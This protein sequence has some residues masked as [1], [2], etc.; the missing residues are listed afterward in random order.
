MIVKNFP[1]KKYGGKRKALQTAKAHRDRMLVSHRPLSRAEFA[2]VL[3]R[4]NKSGVPGVCLVRC[5]YYLVNGAERELLYW[6]AIWPSA[7]SGR[8]TKR[9]SVKTHG[10]QG[11]FELACRARR[12]GLRK[13]KGTFWASARGSV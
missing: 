12:T 8:F 3:R 11:A 4:N 9:F 2:N 5:K 6:E 10:M 1:D 13:V 7:V